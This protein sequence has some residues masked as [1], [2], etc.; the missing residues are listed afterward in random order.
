MTDY[1]T[2][3]AAARRHYLHSRVAAK[4]SEADALPTN[5]RQLYYDGQADDQWPDDSEYLLRKAANYEA[6]RRIALRDQLRPSLVP[7]LVPER[8]RG[9]ASLRN[10]CSSCAPGESRTPN[11]LIRNQVLYPLSYERIYVSV[12]SKRKVR[13]RVP[14]LSTRLRNLRSAISVPRRSKW[15]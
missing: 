10:P 1:G 7:A 5:V 11:R 14:I 6:R 2:G 9:S 12:Q 8:D 15:L 4:R 3:G 13:R